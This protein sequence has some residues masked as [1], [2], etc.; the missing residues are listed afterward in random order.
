MRFGTGGVY[1]GT[2]D[3]VRYV[4]T[5]AILELVHSATGI[6]PQSTTCLRFS[7]FGQVVYGRSCEGTH[8]DYINPTLF[9]SLFDVGR[10]RLIPQFSKELS[11]V[12]GY[13]GCVE[14]D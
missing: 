4:Q 5:A 8:Y 12:S 14:Y 6:L 13:V 1:E 11:C 7:V 9:T 10:G 2:A 3:Y